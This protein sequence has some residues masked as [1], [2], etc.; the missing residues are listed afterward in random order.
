MKKEDTAMTVS[1]ATTLAKDELAEIPSEANLLGA[2][3]SIAI[4]HDATCQRT[5]DA[6]YRYV[7]YRDARRRGSETTI[8]SGTFED[9]EGA[10]RRAIVETCASVAAASVRR[11]SVLGAFADGL[12]NRGLVTE[13]TGP[14]LEKFLRPIFEESGIGDRFEV[15]EGYQVFKTA[16]D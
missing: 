15:R 11:L 16:G 12:V 8:D 4:A 2:I 7:G 1:P 5:E 14:E 13:L 3:F 10:Y 9:L 6:F